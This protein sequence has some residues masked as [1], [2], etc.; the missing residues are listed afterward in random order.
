MSTQ[1]AQWIATARVL[2][3][4]GFGANG[5]QI[6]AAANHDASTYLEVALASDPDVDAGARATPMPTP[7]VLPIPEGEANP[8]EFARLGEQLDAQMRELTGWW[9]RRM[10]AVEQPVHEKLTFLWHNH[11]ATSAEK[12]KMGAYM[13]VQNQTLRTLKLG[14]FRTL[15]YAMLTDAAMLFWLDGD[16]SAAGAPNENL[17]REFLELFTLGHGNGYTEA[18]VKEGARALTG[19]KIDREDGRPS[20]L[21]SRHDMKSKRVLGVT[22][23]FDAASFCDV[24]LAHPQSATFVVRR[25]WQQLASDNAPPAETVDRLLV[26]Y[27]AGRDLKAL[28]KAI[29]LDPDFTGQRGSIVISPVEWMIGLLRTL[30]VPIE[31]PT[32]LN[33]VGQ[34]LIT[35]GQLPFYPPDV[36]GWP[37]GRAWLSTAS[38][39][40]R[41]WAASKLAELGDLTAVEGAAPDDRID[42]AGYLIGVGAWSDRSVSALKP[43]VNNPPKLV[44]AA[45]NTPEYITS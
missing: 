30:A 39:A 33:A 16:R 15:S 20:L 12:V 35:L 38:T 23:D 28:T 2:R 7:P 34:T 37:R 45:V 40:V 5:P 17:S 13:A 9:L 8:A 31:T 36:A 19:W 25:L 10:V 44:A 29:L 3:R 41:V 18:D 14:D 11:F 22:G 21:A 43:L 24:V 42:A 1:S 4:V 27:G 6:D 32:L 26:A